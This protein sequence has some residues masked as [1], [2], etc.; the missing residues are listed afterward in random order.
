MAVLNKTLG[1]VIGHHLGDV[2]GHYLRMTAVPAGQIQP[3]VGLLEIKLPDDK[4]RYK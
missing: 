2:P 1:P 4:L 3:A